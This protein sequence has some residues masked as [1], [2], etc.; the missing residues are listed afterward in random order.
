MNN[1]TLNEIQIARS[2][3]V[4]EYRVLLTQLPDLFV[5]LAQFC[6][7]QSLRGKVDLVPPGNQV[8]VLRGMKSRN[9]AFL[10][11]ADTLVVRVLTLLNSS[12]NSIQRRYQ[13][14]GSPFSQFACLNLMSASFVTCSS[15]TLIRVLLGCTN[16]F[17]LLFRSVGLM[18]YCLEFCLRKLGLGRRSRLQVEKSA[19]FG[20]PHVIWEELVWA[21]LGSLFLRVVR[22]APHRRLLLLF[23]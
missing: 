4:W 21:C 17:W 8:V 22:K 11:W 19:L 12:L 3:L 20:K 10:A 6:L 9:G 14:L 15:K 18:L 1:F 7:V 13:K 23:I 2:S 16:C 5:P